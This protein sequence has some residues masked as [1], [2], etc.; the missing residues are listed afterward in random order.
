MKKQIIVLSI[1]AVVIY[2]SAKSAD[3]K[4]I[5]NSIIHEK[6]YYGFYDEETKEQ[7]PNGNIV[8]WIKFI[9]VQQIDSIKNA[10][11][12]SIGTI[13]VKKLMQKYFPPYAIMQPNTSLDEMFG[14]LQL[15]V[16]TN[17]FR[18]AKKLMIHT[19]FDCKHRKSKGLST[20]AYNDVGGVENSS[21]TE[22]EWIDIVP[23][24][25]GE[26]MLKVLCS[27]Y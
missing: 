9:S 8:V 7:K 15:E 3:W 14:F 2:G 5:G 23:E 11:R 19:E 16:T 22:N 17:N 4:Y 1:L 10:E 12:D 26:T 24:S 21:S 20:I 27:K 13:A 6:I 25:S 18:T